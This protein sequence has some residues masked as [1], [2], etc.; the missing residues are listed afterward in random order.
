[1][2]TII[3]FAIL[4]H[5][6]NCLAV[7]GCEEDHRYLKPPWALCVAV[8]CHH[9]FVTVW[10]LIIVSV[11]SFCALM[12]PRCYFYPPEVN[13][14]WAGAQRSIVTLFT[15]WKWVTYFITLNKHKGTKDMSECPVCS[16]NKRCSLNVTPKYKINK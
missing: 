14:F 16:I 12:V 9:H 5:P 3:L 11:G 7:A 8:F 10:L 4:H 2:K 13:G 6:E 15:F 1:M